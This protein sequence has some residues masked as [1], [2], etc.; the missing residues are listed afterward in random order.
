[1]KLSLGMEWAGK[2]MDP[3]LDKV[4]LAES[5]DFD[6]V[7]CAEAYG[8][9]ALTPL[10]W[11]GA[12]TERIR[13]ATSICQVGARPP[14]NCAMQFNTLDLLAGRGRAVIGLGLSGPQIIEGWYGQPWGRPYWVMRD[15]VAIIRKI[16][17]RDGPVEHDGKA[18]QLPTRAAGSCG[19]GKPLK[20]ILQTNPNIPIW[21]G[22]GSQTM[23]TLTAEIADGWIPMGFVPGSLPSY[24]PWLEEGFR[25][26]GG[27]KSLRDF[28]IQC[29]VQVIIDKDVQAAL[30]RL[31]PLIAFYVGGMGHPQLNFHKEMMIRRGYPEAA[32]SIGQHFLS[33]RRELAAAAV[34]DQ[35]VDDGALVGPPERI[36]ERFRRWLDA[37][38]AGLTL[39]EADETAIRLIA[40]F[41]REF[42]AAD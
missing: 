17:R 15:Y 13:L 8:S 26:A 35:Y 22:T 21:L 40:G 33:G 16:L 6:A 29:G 12:H 30:N 25:R 34:P 5:L 38:V 7:F 41:N 19:Y 37:G 27:G 1:M 9:D 11:I 14:A 4:R 28:H 42:G 2:T 10:T 32:E 31:K 39:Y 24:R 3:A 20:S 36:R 18:L 23:V